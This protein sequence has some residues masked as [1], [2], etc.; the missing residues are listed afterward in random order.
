M[1]QRGLF[2]DFLFGGSELSPGQSPPLV[3]IPK[4][5]HLIHKAGPDG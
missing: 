3:Q 5:C 4:A 2:K 1:F